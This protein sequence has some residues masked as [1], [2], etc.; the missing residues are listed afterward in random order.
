MKQRI[1][2]RLN[3]HAEALLKNDV[4]LKLVDMNLC[5]F[6][7]FECIITDY[8]EVKKFDSVV[9]PKL[10]IEGIHEI[11]AKSNFNSPSFPH[12]NIKCEDGTKD[13]F[14]KKQAELKKVI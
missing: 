6:I 7:T 4:D 13:E 11:L 14:D 10:N 5:M 2:D 1:V 9:A 12:H 3:V 8:S